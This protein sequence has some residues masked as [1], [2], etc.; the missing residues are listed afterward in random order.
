MF[1]KS[2]FTSNFNL[3]SLIPG[4]IAATKGAVLLIPVASVICAITNLTDCFYLTFSKMFKFV[5]LILS[6]S[7]VSQIAN[8]VIYLVVINVVNL[9]PSSGRLTN[10]HPS[11]KTGNVIGV[12]LMILIQ[13]LHK[14]IS[15]SI[16]TY[17]KLTQF[18]RGLSENSTI[19]C[20]KV[21]S[22]QELYLFHLLSITN[23]T[24]IINSSWRLP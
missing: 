20:K 10:K 22:T 24:T 6:I 18:T 23:R 2:T 16:S 14:F 12:F 5:K 21:V 17:R 15:F 7:K 9:R 3:M 11:Y 4:F 19:F 13:Q 1:V 8:M